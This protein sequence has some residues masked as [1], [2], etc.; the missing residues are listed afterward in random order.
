LYLQSLNHCRAT[1]E[2][3]IVSHKLWNILLWDLSVSRKLR[4]VLVYFLVFL[5]VFFWTVP[6][7]FTSTLVELQN[8]T[9][10]APFLK[11]GEITHYFHG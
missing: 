7:A 5:L 10:I 8:L 9:K 2:K 11:P 3:N 6:V 4:T 1:L